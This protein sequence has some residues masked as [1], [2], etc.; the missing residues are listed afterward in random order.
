M[1]SGALQ[2][3][4]YSPY[5][6]HKLEGDTSKVSTIYIR[7]KAPSIKKAWYF[8]ENLPIPTDI[9]NTINHP[10]TDTNAYEDADTF[11][12]SVREALT[13]YLEDVRSGMK[14]AT[15][16]QE[17][18]EQ[19]SRVTCQ[20]LTEGDLGTC[21]GTVVSGETMEVLNEIE[22]KMERK[23]ARGIFIFPTS[24]PTSSPSSN[25]AWWH[26]SNLGLSARR[27]QSSDKIEDS[28][29]RPSPSTTTKM[30]MAYHPE[31]EAVE[32]NRVK[33]NALSKLWKANP[34]PQFRQYVD[35][36]LL[37]AG[38]LTVD[39]SQKVFDELPSCEVII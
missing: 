22:R 14:P 2:D 5:Q 18:L 29:T 28:T 6:S 4:T 26:P 30:W 11:G 1:Y 13:K 33:G 12:N 34:G 31:L 17:Q 21:T 7:P 39:C 8:D 3:A 35:S 10:G 36:A 19:F 23:K 24:P 27:S 15:K 20:L 32:S 25:P 9:C 38:F 37:N 16:L